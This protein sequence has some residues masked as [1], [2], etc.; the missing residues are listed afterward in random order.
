MAPLTNPSL[1]FHK[2]AFSQHG[3]VFRRHLQE[4]DIVVLPPEARW[5]HP[6][7]LWWRTLKHRFRYDFTGAIEPKPLPQG[8]YYIGKCTSVDIQFGAGTIGR[9]AG[10]T[11]ICK[12]GNPDCAETGGEH[13]DR[14]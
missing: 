3:I 13:D 12:C 9:V 7:D 11:C 4:G 1:A 8:Y 6:I 14:L 2:D 10:F 5:W